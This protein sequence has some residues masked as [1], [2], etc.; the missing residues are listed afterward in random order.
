MTIN[1]Y[2]RILEGY[3]VEIKKVRL[4]TQTLLNSLV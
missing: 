1:L 2:I 4:I 3:N